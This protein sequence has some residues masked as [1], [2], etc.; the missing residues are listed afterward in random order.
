M[1]HILSLLMS[2]EIN[3]RN[4]FPFSPLYV[5][6]VVYITL[7]LRRERNILTLNDILCCATTCNDFIESV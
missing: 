3:S 5:K 1:V 4:F 2:G 7:C 6:L